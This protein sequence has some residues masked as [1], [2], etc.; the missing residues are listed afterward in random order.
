MSSSVL[1]LGGPLYASHAHTRANRRKVR[2]WRRH[3]GCRALENP[4]WRLPE[5]HLRDPAAVVHEGVVYL[6]FT[7]YGPKAAT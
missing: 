4:L 2:P 7:Y 1:P 5:T 3:K 6:Y